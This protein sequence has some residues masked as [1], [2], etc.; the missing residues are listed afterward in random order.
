MS[1]FNQVLALEGEAAAAPS[2]GGGG[3]TW[4]IMILFLA[5]MYFLMIR[6]QNKRDKEQREMR[7]NVEIGDGV[8]TIGGIVGRVVSIKDETILL[9]T[10]SDRVRIRLQKWAIQSVEK[11]KLED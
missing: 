3:F 4:V 1:L 10:G 5:V 2:L 11:L 9:E 7:N 8:T 6:P